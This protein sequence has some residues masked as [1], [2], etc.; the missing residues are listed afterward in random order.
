MQFKE[1]WEAAQARLDAWWAGEVLDRA[2]MQ[3]DAPRA[4]TQPA[5]YDG[6]AL[7][8]NI[9]DPEP[10]FDAFEAQCGAT[11][12]GG[13]AF[14]NLWTN[15]GPGIMGAYIGAE[16]RVAEDTVWFETPEDWETV[17]A[18]LAFDETNV[19][20]QRTLKA[21]GQAVARGAEKHFVAITDLGGN[22]DI[23][24]SLRGTQTLLLDLLTEAERVRDATDRIDALWFQYYDALDAIIQAEM[25]GTSAWMGIWCPG[26]WYPLQCDFS[27]MISPEQFE[28]FVAPSLADACNRL[29][30]TIYH[31]DGPGQ[32]PHLDVLLEIPGLDGIQWV[33]GTGNPGTDSEKWYPLYRRIQERGMRLV[34]NGVAPSAVERLLRD[35]QP[36]G[37][38]LTVHCETEAEAR[39]LLKKAEAWTTARR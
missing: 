25:K 19:W 24:A 36:E 21:T 7:A 18:N 29:D 33:P 31:W 4:G 38:L 30:R 17:E 10:V 16:P 27:A 26:R 20:W 23:L 39:E 5:H 28:T 34:L 15:L 3:V 22:L 8:N 37:L 14:P 32:I 2:V 6:W 13:E 35:L 11:F 1:D 9:D 12:F